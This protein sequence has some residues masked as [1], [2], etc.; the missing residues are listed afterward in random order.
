M[1]VI[2]LSN[3]AIPMAGIYLHIPYCR[4]ACYYCDFH[5]STNLKSMDKMVDAMCLEI[6]MRSAEISEPI[7]TIY[8]GGGTPSTLS[9][10]LLEKLIAKLYANFNIHEKV[11]FTAEVN[12]DDLNQTYLEHIKALGINRLSIGVQSFFDEHL[13]W[14]NRSHNAQN[15]QESIKTA[16]K[17]GFE[18][19]SIDLIYGFNLL[20]HKQWEYNIKTAMDS[21]L[22]HISCYALTIEEKTP[23]AKISAKN[24]LALTD[25]LLAKKNFDYLHNTLVKNGWEHY[26]ISNF[27]FQ[28]N[29]STHN[30]NYWKGKSYL[31]I[32]PGAHSYDG[33]K[34]RQWNMADNLNYIDKINR[35]SPFFTS[36]TLNE[37]DIRNEKIMVGLRTAQGI[38][39]KLI[40]AQL[41]NPQHKVHQF[42]ENGLAKLTPT[43]FKLTTEGW[44]FS[45]SIIAAL[46]EV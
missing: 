8:F 20:S 10:T 3:F 2:L 4:K 45:D 29:Y 14:M 15:A 31:G 35:D 16:V 44:W 41:S 23:F 28:K 33:K 34:M 43:S 1:K 27:A 37:N 13:Q 12:P 9:T 18:V 30:Q 25:E 42:I 46:F 5:F 32:G 11:E 21:G 19:S 24:K 38:D 6:E 22:Q 40:S 26:E 39:T 7:E 17:L 36:E